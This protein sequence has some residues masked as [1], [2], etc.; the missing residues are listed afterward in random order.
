M[1][2]LLPAAS[3]L[4]MISTAIA[5]LMMISFCLACGAN[6]SPEEIRTIKLIMAGL[7]LLSL[8]GIV[9]GIILL[10]A[11]QPGWSLASSSAPTLIMMAILI[12]S[13]NA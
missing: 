2:Y 4:A 13:V 6:A 5:T 8:A 7:S 12:V 3:I 11:S 1:P 10:K 9:G